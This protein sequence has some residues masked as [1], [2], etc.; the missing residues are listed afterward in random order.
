MLN[1]S[2]THIPD[3]L[4]MPLKA[5]LFQILYKLSGRKPAVDHLL[6]PWLDYRHFLPVIRP[7][8]MIPEFETSPISISTLPHGP[9]ATP[10]IDTLTVLKAVVGF[11]ARKILEIGSYKGVTALHMAANT[12]E[13]TTLYTLDRDPMH[14]EAY[15]ESPLKR[16]ITRLVGPCEQG[17][18]SPHAPFD[19]IFVDADH[20]YNSVIRH[21]MVAME[22]LDSGGVIMWHDYRHDS[23]LHGGCAVAEALDAVSRARGVKIWALEGTTLAFHSRRDIT[24]LAD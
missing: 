17:I 8:A 13:S 15:A 24:A 10:L 5:R 2:S 9:W 1:D 22:V 6:T 4:R 18:F 16:K 19:F 11:K 3:Q 21:S 23:F 7:S 14:G 12:P 20:D